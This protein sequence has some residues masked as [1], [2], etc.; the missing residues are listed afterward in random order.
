M[1]FTTL[2]LLNTAK[3]ILLCANCRLPEQQQQLLPM[4]ALLPWLRLIE[5]TVYGTLFVDSAG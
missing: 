3:Q 5:E 2:L 4:G 1:L